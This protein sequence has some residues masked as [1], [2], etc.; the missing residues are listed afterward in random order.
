MRSPLADEA[1][2]AGLIH[3]IGVIAAHH[4]NMM[5]EPVLGHE[6]HQ[7]A[8]AGDAGHGYAAVHGEGRVGE[9][10]A[11]AFV[12]AYET[13]AGG[14]APFLA[15]RINGASRN[16]KDKMPQGAMYEMKKFYYDPTKYGTYM[17]QLGIK[18][19]TVKGIVP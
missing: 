11:M 14:T 5:L 17:E 16:L 13:P 2:L 6:A 1:F 10:A 8:Q 9:L 19:P 12:F 18:Y 3:D 15:G 4:G 7:L